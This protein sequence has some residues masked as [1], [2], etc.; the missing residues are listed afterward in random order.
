MRF[1]A[2]SDIHSGVFSIV[3]PTPHV[4]EFAPFKPVSSPYLI[5][6]G[7][8]DKVFSSADGQNWQNPALLIIGSRLHI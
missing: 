5:A 6:G 4:I 7:S 3:I 2:A 8:F 1:K